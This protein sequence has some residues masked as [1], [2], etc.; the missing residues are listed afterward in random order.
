LYTLALAGKAEMGAMNRLKERKDISV[1][2]KWR[3]AAAYALAGQEETAKSLVNSLSTTI[4]PYNSTG[5]SYG[6]DTRDE[7]MI[8]ETLTLIKDRTKAAPLVK[9][10]A[11]RLSSD[12]WYST[13]TTAYGLLAISQF[14]MGEKGSNISFNYTFN[15]KNYSKSVSKPI[16]KETLA[17]S[18]LKGN[19][20]EVKNSGNNVLFVRVINTGQ[21]SAGNEAAASNNL[22]ISVRYTDM[23][24]NAINVSRIEQGTDFMAE[25]TVRHPG[26]RGAYEDLALTHIFPSGW[27]IINQRMDASVAVMNASQPDYQD[28][29][30]DRVY[31][32][33]DLQRNTT[34]TFRIKLNASYLGKFYL[35]ATSIEAMYDNTIN[36][37]TEGQWVEVVPAG[38]AVAMK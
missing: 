28:V 16:M 3:L 25:V 9:S 10:L 6:S 15:G 18:Q 8:I 35:P 26:T 37:R 1:A 11:Q 19:K 13:Q 30:D 21:P 23:M 5:Y 32:Y 2:A 12:A 29:R 7:A 27:E 24:G 17:L 31:S 4:V 20:I 14:A 36:A 33:F 38:R 22:A 34:K